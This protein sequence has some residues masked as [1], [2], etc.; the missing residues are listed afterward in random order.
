MKRTIITA[1]VIIAVL[2]TVAGAFAFGILVGPGSQE[3]LLPM[4]HDPVFFNELGYRLTEEGK[5]LEAQAAFARAIELRPE[6]ERARANLATIAFQN[7]DYTAAIE[8]LR[9]LHDSA[10][11]NPSYTFDLA[12]N[13]VHQARYVDADKAKLEEAAALFE[14]IPDYPNAAANA[15]VVRNVIA[16]VFA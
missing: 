5:P 8:Q 14:S 1:I 6:Y 3:Q 2:A 7:A 16:D 13:L 15:V 11:A 10:P 9:W 12:Q 4:A